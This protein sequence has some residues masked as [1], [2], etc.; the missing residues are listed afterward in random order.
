MR[1]SPAAC[2]ALLLAAAPTAADGPPDRSSGSSATLPLEELLE[3]HDQA[4]V[5]EPKPV[6]PPVAA[7]LTEAALTGRLLDRAL[8]VT[9]QFKVAVLAEDWVRVPLMRLDPAV[10]VQSV[11]PS[12]NGTVVID[13]GML[14]LVTRTPGEH[15]VQA[16]LLMDARSEGRRRRVELVVQQPAAARL[17]VR[18]DADLFRLRRAGAT[19]AGEEHVL[20]PEHDRF[21]V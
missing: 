10:H 18:F 14:V 13:G 9:A 16:T 15:A 12:E 6:R 8:D 1:H 20:Y 2:L 7:A 11:T 17:R 5:K 3:L 4:R 21:V 19:Q